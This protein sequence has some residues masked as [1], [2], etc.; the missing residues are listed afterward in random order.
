[1]LSVG[2]FAKSG[3]PTS[4]EGGDGIF[5][6]LIV[7]KFIFPLKKPLELL[8]YTSFPKTASP[9]PATTFG[10]PVMEN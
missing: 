4:W 1:V 3:E 2:Q 8:T 10:M 5:V 9:P 6:K 7:V